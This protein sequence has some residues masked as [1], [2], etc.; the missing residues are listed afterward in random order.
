MKRR[1]RYIVVRFHNISE[2]KGED[3][4]RN[5]LMLY[6]PFRDE[7]KDLN[8]SGDGSFFGKYQMVQDHVKKIEPL[9]SKDTTEFNN[10]CDNRANCDIV[11]EWS[12][13]G[14][15]TAFL[16]AE[17]ERH[18]HIVERAIHEEQSRNIDIEGEDLEENHTKAL[19]T[20]EVDKTLLSNEEYN[21]MITSLNSK[22]HQFM[23]HHRHWL[24]KV[25]TALQ[26]NSTI[27]QFNI[28]LS[29][30]GG[31]GKSHIIKLVHHET[32]VLK[33]KSSNFQPNDI[34]VLLTAFT[35]TAAFEIDG[36]TI[37][38]A[39]GFTPNKDYVPLSSNK[40]N[41]IRMFLSKLLVLIIDEV[42]MVGSDFLYKIHRR[43]VEIKG[44]EA[45]FGGV[46]VLA[47]G[48]LFQ[49]P[50]VCQGQ[51]FDDPSIPLA[52]LE[53]SMWKSQFSLFELTQSMR[54]KDDIGFSELLG[55]V[56]LGKCSKTD[57]DVLMS[58][59]I[60]DTDHLANV[61]HVFSTNRA[62]DQHNH[63]ML[64]D[65]I[66]SIFSF[67]S[68]DKAKDSESGLIKFNFS[69]CKQ[70]ETGNLRELLEVGVGARVMLTVNVDVSDG[71]VNGVC[72][73]VVGFD[74]DSSANV[75]IIFVQFDNPCVGRR[76]RLSVFPGAVAIE[77]KE[78]SFSV[79]Y[80]KRV[81]GYRLQFPLNLAWACTI[82]KVQGKTMDKIVVSMKEGNFMAGQAYV[83]FSR[84]KKL[85]GLYLVGFTSKSIRVNDAAICEME[86]LSNGRSI[87]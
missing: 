26:N 22:Q 29:G 87:Q 25:S 6:Y 68:V 84:V 52:R 32:S 77:R 71:L 28:F 30:P 75:K 55:R 46:S 57:Y 72:G 43:L 2:E 65:K 45:P 1:K 10:A 24:R 79:K 66:S 33:Q 48:D 23:E 62:V 56:R 53:G 50:P 69:K 54:Q 42:S 12:F 39:L 31:V 5:M 41:T 40:L 51:V 49:L 13:L 11:E 58:R 82:H 19:F 18:G 35:G 36:M 70:S 83:A 21:T 37:H 78:V 73:T 44:V 16:Q 63:K 4:Y 47:V 76:K 8:N 74:N 67:T 64:K 34:V 9:F 38:S 86:R 7:S 81:I 20:K 59:N 15:N 80:G 27:P 85:Q 61:L 17:Q 14:P 3:Y 60:E